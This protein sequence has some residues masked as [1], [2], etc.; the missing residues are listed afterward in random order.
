M[1]IG[2]N[3][4]ISTQIQL[5]LFSLFLLFVVTHSC[6]SVF[7]IRSND[8]HLHSIVSLYQLLI[9]SFPPLSFESLSCIWWDCIRYNDE[10][11]GRRKQPTNSMLELFVLEVLGGCQETQPCWPNWFWSTSWFSSSVKQHILYIILF[12]G[13]SDDLLDSEQLFDCLQILEA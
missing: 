7:C 9:C 6:K 1:S 11:G 4:E 3:R 10:V 2:Q 13:L 12:D 8:A 5:N